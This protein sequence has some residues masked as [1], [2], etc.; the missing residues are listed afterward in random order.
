VTAKKPNWAQQVYYCPYC[1]RGKLSYLWIDDRLIGLG[2]DKWLYC[3]KCK[4]KFRFGIYGIQ[5]QEI[6]VEV[7]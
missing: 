3:P 4:K 7:Q 5:E 1:S 2:L 6:N